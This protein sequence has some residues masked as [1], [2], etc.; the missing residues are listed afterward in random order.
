MK[1]NS[2]FLF[3]YDIWTNILFMNFSKVTSSTFK[4]VSLQQNRRRGKIRFSLPSV[5]CV[6]GGEVAQTMY[7]HVSN[8]KNEKIK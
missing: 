1:Q 6:G 4:I 2:L 3:T 5:V 7:T 8:C